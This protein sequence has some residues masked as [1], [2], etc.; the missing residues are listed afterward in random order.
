MIVRK[1]AKI[2]KPPFWEPQ[3]MKIAQQ[4][5][6]NQLVRNQVNYSPGTDQPKNRLARQLPNCVVECGE[7]G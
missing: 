2:E 4:K 1:V 7:F 6:K 3:N 5:L